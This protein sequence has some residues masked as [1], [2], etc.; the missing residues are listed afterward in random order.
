MLQQTTWRPATSGTAD[1]VS[2]SLNAAG[3]TASGDSDLTVGTGFETINVAT[4]GAAST[5]NDIVT[6][7]ATTMN[8]TGDQNLTVRL[9]LDET[10]NVINA[11]AFTGNLSILTVD[12]TTTP[13]ATVS[14]VDVADI[15][16]T[17]GSGRRYYQRG[18]K[19]C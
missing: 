14:S 19:R 7:S 3:S 6:S 8:I 15:T 2:V 5:L 9:G 10:L 4:T 11:S 13:D 16:I 17:G 1:T 18:R 12:D